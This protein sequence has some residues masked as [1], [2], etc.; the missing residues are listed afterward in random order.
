MRV[1]GGAAFEVLKIAGIAYL[2][3]MAWSTWREQGVLSLDEA[4]PAA[5]TLRTISN[6]VLANLLN[7]N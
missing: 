4:A 6:A 1:A 2:L 5:S 7:P 3:H